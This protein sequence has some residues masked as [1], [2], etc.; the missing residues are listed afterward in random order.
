V[1]KY[2]LFSDVKNR[3]IEIIQDRAYELGISEDVIFSDGFFLGM[4]TEKL[5]SLESDGHVIPMISLIGKETSRVYLFS[6][7]V[8]LGDQFDNYW[9]SE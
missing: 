6:V 1:K 2:M 4:H 8:L 9:K 3:I 7:K 5:V